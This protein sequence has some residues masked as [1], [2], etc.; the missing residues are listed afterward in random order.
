MSAA[1][2]TSRFTWSSTY[3]ES[4]AAELFA[5]HSR[6]GALERL[7]PPWQKNTILSRQ[8]GIAPGGEVTLRLQAGPIS[9]HYRG[10]H[11]AWEPGRMFHD[12]QERGPFASWSHRHSFHDSP[13]GSV[14]E[15]EVE[16][17]LPGHRFLPGWLHRLVDQELSRLFRHRREVLLADLAL[18]RR[19]SREPLRI[20]ISGASGVLGQ[21]LCPLLTTGGHRL[22]TL[23]RRPPNSA[24]E[25][26][27]EPMAGLL[28]PGKIPAVDAVIHLAGEYIGLRRWS[29][30]GKERVLTSRRQGTDLL[31]R[32][33]AALP[34]PPRVLLSAS[35]TGYYGDSGGSEVAEEASAG[36]DFISFVCRQWEEATAPAKAAGIRTVTMRLGVGLTPHAG[37]LARILATGPLGYIRRF[38]HGDQY[39]SWISND[40]MVAAMLHCLATPSLAGP[41]N[42][43]APEPVTNAAFMATL[44]LLTGRPLLPPLPAPFLRLLYGQ[45]AA[46][47][48]LSGC[49]ASSR[50]LQDSGFRFRHP[51]L[52]TALVSLL[53]L[54]GETP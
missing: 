49:R 52:T 35:A 26:F 24:D 4:T 48:V 27:W 13:D 36:R 32:T 8:G 7:L 51:T 47:I 50:K 18:H 14:L 19:C 28:D 30:S 34:R 6:Q 16:F 25:I 37:G 41:I 45:M 22:F 53:G 29:A 10:R 33:L 17:A 21:R 44:A 38:G 43:V 31:C 5:W 46:E 3:P 54:R 42:I 2:R 39:I 11:I 9:F 1:S 40:D 20:L 15:D 23:V 12:I